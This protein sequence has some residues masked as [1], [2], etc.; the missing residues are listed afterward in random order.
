MFQPLVG[1]SS[2]SAP[3]RATEARGPEASDTPLVLGALAVL[4][5]AALSLGGCVDLRAFG[6][7]WSG[8]IVEEPAIRQGFSADVEVD[9]LELSDVSLD[10]LSAKLTTSDDK[11][12][13]TRLI[14]VTRAGNDAL[15]SLTFDGD[16]LRSYLLYAHVEDSD[17]SSST[18]SSAARTALVLVSLFSDDRVELR[19]LRSNSLYGVFRLERQSTSR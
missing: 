13:A 17:H 11:F 8:P 3:G 10:G 18:S 12:D 16:P 6:G 9:P 4:S 2:S 15:A 14:P 19:I 7:S 1:A 5:A